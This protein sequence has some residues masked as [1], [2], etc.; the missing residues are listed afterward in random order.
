[1]NFNININDV[2]FLFS[3]S[4]NKTDTE[5][6]TEVSTLFDHTVNQFRQYLESRDQEQSVFSRYSKLILKVTVLRT[7]DEEIVE[8]LFFNNLLQQIRISSII[9]YIVSLGGTGNDV[10][11]IMFYIYLQKKT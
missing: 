7:F 6:T 5:K 2:I 11:K 9:P 3:L 10:S 4:I 1:M 8:Q